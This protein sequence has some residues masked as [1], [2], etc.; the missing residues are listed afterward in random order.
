LIPNQ[1]NARKQRTK[2]TKP[3]K[4]QLATLSLENVTLAMPYPNWLPGASAGV[5]ELG[6]AHI[7]K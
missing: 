6:V 2:R 5:P 3:R 1:I 4:G 7:V